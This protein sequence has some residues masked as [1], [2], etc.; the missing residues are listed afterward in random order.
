MSHHAVISDCASNISRIKRW[1]LTPEY[2]LIIAYIFPFIEFI[3]LV[4]GSRFR[5][6]PRN[7]EKN[8][9]DA[10]KPVA[11]HFPNNSK[12]HMAVCSLSLYLHS[13]F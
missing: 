7:L 4:N 5:E 10:S 1:S 9:K 8:D 2:Y 6:Q 11:K 13:L 3:Q 12:Q